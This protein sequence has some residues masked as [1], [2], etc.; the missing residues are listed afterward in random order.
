MRR[1]RT[2]TAGLLM[3]TMV[4]SGT[5]TADEQWCGSDPVF[6]IRGT[7]FRLTAS[8]RVAASEVTGVTFDVTLPADAAGVTTVAHP[9]GGRFP[10][11]VNVTYA[12]ASSDDAYP[13]TAT[14]TV[15]SP[16]SAAVRVD[17]TGPSVTAASWDI[18]TNSSFTTVF[19]AAK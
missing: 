11:T 4:M 16:A 19:S 6:N 7:V 10:I 13:V 15:S 9:Q 17:L 14:I 18:S 1:L 8:V 12:G 5:A 3:A 2:L